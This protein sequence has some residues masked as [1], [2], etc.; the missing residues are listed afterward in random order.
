MLTHRLLGGLLLLSASAVLAPGATL[1]GQD[2]PPSVIVYAGGLE[3]VYAAPCAPG[4]YGTI[5]LHHGFRLPASSEWTSS[6]TDL[7]D[8]YNQFNTP[9]QKCAA[10]YFSNEY[11][12]CDFGNFQSGYVYDSPFAPDDAHRYSSWSETFLVRGAGGE[13]PEPAS[14]VLLGSG[15]IAV[16]VLRRR[17][18]GAL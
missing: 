18:A 6:F 17:R 13:I 11:D 12:H 8:M 14:Y 15:L 4:V 3:W 10:T 5:T 2:P 7:S 9:S 1:I 16:A